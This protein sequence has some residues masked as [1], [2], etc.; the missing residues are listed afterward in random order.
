MTRSLSDQIDCMKHTLDDRYKHVASAKD[1][2]SDI[3]RE[4]IEKL[5]IR[6][7]VIQLSRFHR[8]YIF[9]KLMCDDKYD[10]VKL[11]KPPA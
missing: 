9:A 1:R 6:T 8:V 7:Q 5:M 4:R 2:T 11:T 10:T 3:H